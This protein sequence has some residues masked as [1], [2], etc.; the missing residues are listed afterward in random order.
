MTDE[1]M[2]AKADRTHLKH[3]KRENLGLLRGHR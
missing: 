2:E 1:E 3:T